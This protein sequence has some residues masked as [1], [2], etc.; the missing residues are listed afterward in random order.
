MRNS[1]FSEKIY[2]FLLS[3][4]RWYLLTPERSLDEAYKAALNIRALENEH[5]NGNKVD[6][7]SPIYSKSVMDYFEA[8]LAKQLKIARMR[9]TEF[10]FSRWFSN[11]SNQK[12][13]RKAGIDYPSPAAILEKLKFIDDIISK[14]TIPDDEIAPA[15][16]SGVTIKESNSVLPNDQSLN[17]PVRSHAIDKNNLVERIYTPTS[18]PQLVKKTE[19]NKRP[20]GKAD[21]TGV[22]PRS[23]LSTIGRLQ[24]ELDPNAEKDVVNNFRQAQRRSIGRRKPSR[25]PSRSSP[26]PCPMAG[27]RLP[28]GCIRG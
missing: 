7:N 1:I 22:L 8:D 26:R 3:A 19:Q 6:L 20:K 23:I 28:G 16:V 15:E 27:H 18:S 4:Y 21:T 25:A 24:I 17:Y 9:L 10:R 11:E 5:F 14:Y 13:A 12:A 2:P